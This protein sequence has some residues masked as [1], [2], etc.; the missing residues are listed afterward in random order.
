MNVIG[1]ITTSTAGFHFHR[2]QEESLTLCRMDCSLKLIYISYSMRTPS[3]STLMYI[4]LTLYF[5]KVTVADDY[6]RTIIRLYASFSISV[7]SPVNISIRSFSMILND[8]L[9]SFY[10][11]TSGRQS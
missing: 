3:Q 2:R 1:L 6:L 4:Y 9:M 8:P 7:I 10:V 5:Y 11:G